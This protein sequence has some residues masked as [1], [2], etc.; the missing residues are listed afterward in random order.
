M[1]TNY[2]FLCLHA[3]SLEHLERVY[4]W[5]LHIGGQMAHTLLVGYKYIPVRACMIKFECV[6]MHVYRNARCSWCLWF[7]KR[8]SASLK[9]VKQISFGN[10][11]AFSW[12]VEI[13]SLLSLYYVLMCI[14]NIAMHTYCLNAAFHIDCWINYNQQLQTLILRYRGHMRDMSTIYTTTKWVS[15]F[16]QPSLSSMKMS[17]TSIPGSKSTLSVLLSETW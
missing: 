11:M 9:S 6:S 13:L 5:S 10:L 8:S 14:Y 17:A 4:T 7:G 2:F 15:F 1:L 16:N 12:K 3:N